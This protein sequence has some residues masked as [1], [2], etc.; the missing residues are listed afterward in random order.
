MSNYS[1]NTNE[2][3]IWP[4]MLQGQVPNSPTETLNTSQNSQDQAIMGKQ[5][6]QGSVISSG[7]KQQQQPVSTNAAMATRS[8]KTPRGLGMKFF[9]KAFSSRDSNKTFS[10]VYS[11]MH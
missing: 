10:G 11:S 8:S 6:R 4:G 9:G 7:G 1:T 5:N 3:E 2:T